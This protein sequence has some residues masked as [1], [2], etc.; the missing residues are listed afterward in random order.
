MRKI[1]GYSLYCYLT[2][3]NPNN[4]LHLSNAELLQLMSQQ[5]YVEVHIYTLDSS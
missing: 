1:C 2:L 3:L 4:P 5:E